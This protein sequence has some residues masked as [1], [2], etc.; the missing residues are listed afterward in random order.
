MSAR[1]SSSAVSSLLLLMLPAC[2]TP[3]D[4]RSGI[5]K[6]EELVMRVER[7]HADVESVRES[8]A[9]AVQ[10]LGE[11]VRGG[12]DGEGVSAVRT[13]RRDADASRRCAS[14]LRESVASMRRSAEP[15]FEHWRLQ[16]EGITS[17]RV[18]VR[19]AMRMDAMRVNYEAI[20]SHI[21]P[22]LSNHDALLLAL[23]DL[24]ARMESGHDASGLG[25]ARDDLAR[26]ERTAQI[27]DT[28]LQSCLTAA[29]VYFA[30]LS[31]T[32]PLDGVMSLAS[33]SR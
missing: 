11:L 3:G 28:S 9:V 29:Q 31:P 32:A 22:A 23:A 6:F 5:A 4:D 10:G 7:V 21:V 14:A 8:M 1:V 13:L 19:S 20:D 2:A 15:V 24:E 30:G 12:V 18:R 17:E 16:L 27:L 33:P 25:A 26:L